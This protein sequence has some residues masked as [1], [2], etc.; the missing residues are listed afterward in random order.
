MTRLAR[1]LRPA[2]IAV[3]GGG[4]WGEAVLETAKRDGFAG[5]IW[6]VHPN[7]REIA[8]YRSYARVQDL[9][10]APDAAFIAVNRS[11][12]PGLVR[13]LAALGT[14]GAICFASGFRETGDGAQLERDLVDAAGEMPVLGPNCY[15]VINALDGAALWPDRHGLV[16]VSRGVAIVAQSGNILLNLSMQRRGLPI[17]YAVA[18]GNQAQLGL[19]EIGTALIADDRVSALGLH[20]EGVGDVRAL[21]ALAQS[22]EAAGKPIV[23]LKVG[24]SEGAQAA[25]L[26]HTASLTGTATGS[27]ALLARL[28]IAQVERLGAF[29]Q[30]LMLAHHT[31]QLA[32][33]R[34]AVMSCSGGEAGLA[35]DAAAVRG[36]DCPPLSNAQHAALE[37]VLG[38]H[39]ARANPLDYHTHI[40]GDVPKLRAMI[41]AMISGDVALGL[42]VLDFP[43]PELGPVPEWEAAVTAAAAAHAEAAIPL[44]IVASLPDTMDAARAASLAAAGLVPL[45]GLEDAFDAVAALAKRHAP[46]TDAVLLPCAVADR[47]VLNEA[48]AKAALC[49]FGLTVPSG[50]AARGAAAA[51][52]AASLLGDRVVLKGLGAAHKSEAG[53]VVLDLSVD[54]VAAQAEAM[55]AE[56]FL[57]EEH[58]D[59]V[60]AE[61]LIGVV[62]DPA[63][64]FV[65]TLGAGGT[66]TEIIDDTQSM[67]VPASSETVAHALAALRLAPV[68]D[69]YRGRPGIDHGAVLRAVA[70]VQ[71]FVV[72]HADR[73]VELEINPLLCTPDRAVAADAFI[74]W[75][76]I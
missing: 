63:H 34:I 30:A 57:V 39:V 15:G 16:P 38:A 2:S 73:L 14:G 37:A 51:A 31:G 67:L 13:D 26:S 36:I 53:L 50:Q 12:T 28:G 25:G 71:D 61:L 56:E 41:A 66:L 35:A 17:A 60:I 59:G 23:A 10:T 54:A 70:A 68:F 42:L 46:A 21:E 44:A 74:R 18:A 64:G 9:P 7:R 24:R 32:A 58:I 65:L 69:G 1:L 48:Q 55:P 52:R 4:A 33:P 8:G 75:G 3:I 72:A 27:A 49:R 22:A 5:P 11:R 62:A 6:P 19:A 40:W 29:L 20:I 76:P 43:L 45:S 47:E